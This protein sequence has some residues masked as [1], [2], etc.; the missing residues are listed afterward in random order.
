MTSNKTKVTYKLQKGQNIVV[1]KADS[2]GE[3]ANNT[4]RMELIDKK[5]KHHVLT[6]L[7]VGKN[8][9]FKINLQ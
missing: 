2:E 8:L 5:I 9:T 6:E 4:T 7:Q 1:L 3:K